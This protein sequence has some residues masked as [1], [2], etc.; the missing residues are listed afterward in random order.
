[1]ISTTAGRVKVRVIHTDEE[2]M[3][4]RSVLAPVRVTRR[5]DAG[6]EKSETRKTKEL[7]C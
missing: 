5:Q 6:S 7:L 3:I 4:A 1:M 2:L